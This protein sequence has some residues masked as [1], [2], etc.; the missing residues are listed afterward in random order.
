M[1]YFRIVTGDLFITLEL[2]CMAIL[3]II[4]IPLYNIRGRKVVWKR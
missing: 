2:V 3:I 1:S 4:L